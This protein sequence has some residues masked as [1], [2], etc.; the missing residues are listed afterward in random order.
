MHLMNFEFTDKIVKY[1]PNSSPLF[2]ICYGHGQ[3]PFLI[4]HVIL[5]LSVIRPKGKSQ[6]KGS[7]EIKYAKFLKNDYLPV[8]THTCVRVSKD[9]KFSFLGEIWHA[10]LSFYL[11][12]EIVFLPYYRQRI[13]IYIYFAEIFN[14]TY[15]HCS[16]YCSCYIQLNL[17][18]W[19]FMN[20]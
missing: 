20:W 17:Y 3:W 19:L 14:F 9:K 10:L 6:D 1:W 16:L 12:L 2:I 4:V 13:V 8:L 5:V 7:K 18:I 15:T 11:R